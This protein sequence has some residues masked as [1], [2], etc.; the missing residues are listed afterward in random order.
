MQLDVRTMFV[1]TIAVTVILG[2]LLIYAWYQHRKI[3]ALA[4]WGCAHMV[5]SAGV[6]LV[7]RQGVLSDFW[8]IETANALLFVAA[9]MTWTGARLF[10]GNRVSLV[11]T[12]GG[13]IAWLL[14]SQIWNFMSTPHG[15]IVFSSMMIALYTFGA[16]IEF[17]RGREENLLSRLPL[18]V[19]LSMHGVIYFARVPLALLMPGG[20]SE[21]FFSNAWFGVIGLESLLYMIATAFILLAMAKERTEMEHK[22]A[23]SIDSLT[24]ISNRRAF[25]ETA[26]RA[27]KQRT[28]TPQPVSALL[29]DLDRFK[30][31][32]DRY[33]HAVGDRVLRAFAD[34]AAV[35]LRST[36]LLGRLGG[37]EFGAVL[38]GAEAS[39]A[40][41]TAERIR[42]NFAAMPIGNGTQLDVSVSI[43]VA[44]VSASDPTEIENLL[45]RA[46]EALYVAKA[47]GR[48]RIEIADAYAGRAGMRI[49]GDV[50]G[51]ELP[52]RN[53]AGV[54]LGVMSSPA[55][56]PAQEGDL[57][58][59]IVVPGA[60]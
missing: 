6:W 29:F 10:D 41:A 20:K 46:D 32:N 59:S 58:P 17:W 49:G 43:G 23:A 35:E 8:A 19:L 2:C 60:G 26:V 56:T 53:S 44:S 40:A 36:D 25:L 33:G 50:P 14:A 54:A 16:A 48:N 5:A 37:E 39:S 45:T 22:V 21:A 42:R 34:V 9:G 57:R 30:S 51:A 52:A 18:I 3:P 28:R 1:V 24:G 47:R 55:I 13:A 7:S 38:F 11:G 27:L 15:P 12:F 4:W 31:I